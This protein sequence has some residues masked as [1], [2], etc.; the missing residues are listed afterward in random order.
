MELFKRIWI[1]CG[2]EWFCKMKVICDTNF[3]YRV[4]HG[5]VKQED[6]QKV[7]LYATQV[8]LVEL[9]RTP[10]LLTN[11][12][13]VQRAVCAL[14]DAKPTIFEV[15]PIEYIIQQQYPDYKI[16]DR[17]YETILRDF[18]KL[19]RIDASEELPQDALVDM[20][21]SIEGWKDGLQKCADD[22]NNILPEIRANI[23]QTTGKKFHRVKKSLPIF[24]DVIN[25]F[26]R[27]YSKG[28]VELNNDTY[29]WDKILFFITVWDNYFKELEVSGNRRF[30]LND[31]HDL[32]NMVYVSKGFKYC[33]ADN[34]WINII[35]SDKTTIDYLYLM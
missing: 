2:M 4:A 33:T 5:E 34:N 26:V 12:P 21:K 15:N 16:T 17:Q 6:L 19:M 9:S 10:N 3:W 20:K 14:H 11:L 7:K 29:P 24:F 30:D 28:K 22:V 18:E 35:K 23:K 13:L 8:N 32:F 27:E 31:W 1:P 25:L